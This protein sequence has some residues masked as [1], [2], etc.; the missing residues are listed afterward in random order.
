MGK[1]TPDETYKARLRQLMRFS[2]FDPANL[3][4]VNELCR[5]GWLL[6]DE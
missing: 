3:P 4:L 5:R 1:N 2:A 6:D